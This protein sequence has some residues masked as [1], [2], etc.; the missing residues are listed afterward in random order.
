VENRIAEVVGVWTTDVVPEQGNALPTVDVSEEHRFGEDERTIKIVA[1]PAGVSEVLA[2]YQPRSVRIPVT[3]MELGPIGNLAIGAIEVMPTPPGPVKVTNE[4]EI[5]GGQVP[6]ADDQLRDRAKHALERAGQAT[7]NAIKY[8][9]LD[10]DGVEDCE[11]RDHTIDGS[12][13]LGEVR[14]SY[15][16]E[17]VSEA[18]VRS[19]IDNTRA[20]GILVTLTVLRTVII[21]GTI[22]VIPG[23]NAS[24]SAAGLLKT[25]VVRLVNALNAGESLSLRRLTALVYNFPDLAEIAEAQLKFKRD[26]DLAPID[27]DGV[28]LAQRDERVRADEVNLNV[29]LLRTI[30][31]RS[32]APNVVQLS[33]QDANGSAVRFTNMTLDISLIVRARLLNQPEQTREQVRSAQVRLNLRNQTNISVNVLTAGTGELRFRK[34]DGT[35]PNPHDPNNVE[36]IVT[37]ASFPGLQGGQATINLQ[38]P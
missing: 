2:R 28:Y 6:E 1:L 31:L 16:G 36:V 33:L 11:V 32:Q 22:Y 19:V 17:N 7:L 35:E 12:I 24:S 18:Q 37:A 5:R 15:G 29:V 26:G 8:A 30:S 21:S 13:P 25:E 9:V 38:V 27:I 34:D 4:V 20:A 14:V 3:A 10:V 23:A